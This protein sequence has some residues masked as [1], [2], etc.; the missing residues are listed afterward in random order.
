MDEQVVVELGRL[1]LGQG[2]EEDHLVLQRLVPEELEGGREH[3]VLG[4]IAKGAADVGRGR[5]AALLPLALRPQIAGAGALAGV[6][7]GRQG[8]IGRV[9]NLHDGVAQSALH[10]VGGALRGAVQPFVEFRDA[11]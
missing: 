6:E 2:V 7:H 9:S 1:H 11:A 4:G 8:L 10:R 5:G 3:V